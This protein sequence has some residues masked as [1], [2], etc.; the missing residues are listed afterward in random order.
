MKGECPKF[1][2]NNAVCLKQNC[3]QLLC[4]NHQKDQVLLIRY[5]S[6]MKTRNTIICK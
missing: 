6:G 2:S 5:I 3:D 4:Q 1:H